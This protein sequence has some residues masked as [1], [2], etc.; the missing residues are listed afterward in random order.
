MYK[1]ILL[2]SIA[3]NTGLLGRILIQLIHDWF[4]QW[5]NSLECEIII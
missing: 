5:I 4:S 2:N 3:S 1:V